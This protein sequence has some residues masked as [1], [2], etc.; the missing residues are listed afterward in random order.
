MFFCAREWQPDCYI[1]FIDHDERDDPEKPS[2]IGSF[3]GW[4]AAF[5]YPHAS[6]SR[7]RL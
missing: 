4:C 2:A 6:G 7:N 1:R 5:D 3:D